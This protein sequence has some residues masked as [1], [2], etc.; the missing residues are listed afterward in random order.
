[1]VYLCDVCGEDFLKK[2]SLLRHE[3]NIHKFTFLCDLCGFKTDD[4]QT[5]NIHKKE[6]A[7]ENFQC[8][9][10]NKILKTKKTLSQHV[11]DKHDAPRFSCSQCNYKTNRA[12]LLNEHKKTH[13]VKPHVNLLPPK[14][15][16]ADK[17]QNS[18]TPSPSQ[19][20]ETVE[21]VDSTV[22][23]V[24]VRSAFRTKIQERAWYIRG[25]TDPLGA[26][27][28]YKNRIRDVLLLSL[29]KKSTKFLYCS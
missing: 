17:V 23:D 5:S 27:R 18:K 24:A 19:L 12:F 28:A 21:G 7:Q 29:K 10:C 8:N 1:M 25:Y 2:S 20:D 13:I 22:Q 3:N 26:L 16:E 15:V 4:K 6:H 9:Q 14:K 11:R